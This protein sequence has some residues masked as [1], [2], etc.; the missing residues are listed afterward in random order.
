MGAMT[1]PAFETHELQHL[2]TWLDSKKDL[3]YV[4]DIFLTY[5]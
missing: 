1:N 4:S 2:S 3:A 5:K